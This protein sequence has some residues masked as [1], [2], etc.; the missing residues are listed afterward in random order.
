MW[1]MEFL[2]ERQVKDPV[3]SPQQL[4]LL[5]WCGFDSWSGNFHMLRA[6]PKKCG[7]NEESWKSQWTTSR[8]IIVM[9]KQ[10]WWMPKFRGRSLRRNVIFRISSI[11]PQIL[12]NDEIISITVETSGRHHLIRFKVTILP[13]TIRWEEHII[14]V[15][16]LYEIH[17]LKV[18]M[19]KHQ[20]NKSNWRAS[21]KI[22]DWY[23]SKVSVHERQEKTVMDQTG[24]RRNCHRLKKVKKTQ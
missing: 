24:D 7:R 12:I 1:K 4:R 22:P 9:G 19:R 3:L 20:G 17:H 16:K 23:S 18:I 5:L 11:S 21:C 14:S 13:D 2:V 10:H 15:A 8:V 6:W